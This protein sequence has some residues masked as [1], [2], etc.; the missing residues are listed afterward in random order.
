M[1]ALNHY[2]N[3]AQNTFNHLRKADDMHIPFVKLIDW[4]KA[5]VA[6]ISNAVIYYNKLKFTACHGFGSLIHSRL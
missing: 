2:F 6:V 3:L 1:H 5:K 4:I